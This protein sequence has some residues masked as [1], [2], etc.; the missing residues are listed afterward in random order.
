MSNTFRI[1]RKLLNWRIPLYGGL[2]SLFILFLVFVGLQTSLG[3]KALLF[4]EYANSYL[5]QPN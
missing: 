3:G 5:S 1:F 2:G 4:I